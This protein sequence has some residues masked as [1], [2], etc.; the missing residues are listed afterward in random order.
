MDSKITAPIW[1][2][3]PQSKGWFNFKRTT[4]LR[5]TIS[6]SNETLS[7]VAD[8]GDQIENRNVN[9]LKS[10]KRWAPSMTFYFKDNSKFEFFFS[11]PSGLWDAR[12]QAIPAAFGKG[13]FG[14]TFDEGMVNMRPF[15]D[16]FISKGLLDQKG[17]QSE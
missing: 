6:I 5:G 15:E 10:V 11:D 4:R 14:K 12:A 13:P 7:I 8:N 16:Y 1:F 17:K 2:N 9:D 3:Y